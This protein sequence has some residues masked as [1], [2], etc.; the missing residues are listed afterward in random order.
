V[1]VACS[2]LRICWVGVPKFSRSSMVA[3]QQLVQVAMLA[4]GGG[5]A[6]CSNISLC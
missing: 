1:Y 2:W 5:G 4:G 6:V 3:S